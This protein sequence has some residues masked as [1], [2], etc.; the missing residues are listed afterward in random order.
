MTFSEWLC[1]VGVALIVVGVVS[2]AVLQ[3]HFE[4]KAYTNLTGK[5]VSYWDAV[6]LDLRVQEQVR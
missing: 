5:N 3:P 1:V 6:W 4:A 2:I